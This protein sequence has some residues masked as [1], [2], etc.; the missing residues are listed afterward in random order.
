MRDKKI[1]RPEPCANIYKHGRLKTRKE[2]DEDGTLD[3]LAMDTMPDEV[4]NASIDE[5]VEACQPVT[6]EYI[7]SI[8]ELTDGVEVDLDEPLSSDNEL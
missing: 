7:D 3:Q 2:M 8:K 4:K 1:G 5:L 6:Q